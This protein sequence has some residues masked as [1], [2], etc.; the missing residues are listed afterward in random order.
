MVEIA[1]G[2]SGV[3]DPLPRSCGQAPIAQPTLRELAARVEGDEFAGTTAL[4]VGGSR[5]LGAVTARA[6]AAGGGRVVVTYLVGEADARAIEA[7]IGPAARRVVR[8]DARDD[9]APQLAALS[10]GT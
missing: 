2:G 5:G 4:I 3:Q 10:I 1:V 7:E 6:I 9:V 8:Y